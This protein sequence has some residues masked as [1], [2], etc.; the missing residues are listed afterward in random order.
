MNSGSWLSSPRKM[1]LTGMNFG[2]ICISMALVGFPFFNCVFDTLSGAT[3]N[4]ATESSADLAYTPQEK[5]FTTVQPAAVFPAQIP[6]SARFRK[7][8]QIQPNS[9]STPKARSGIKCQDRC[10]CDQLQRRRSVRVVIRFGIFK[11]A[12][13]ADDHLL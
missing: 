8:D 9:S 1:A 11:K 2:I 3:A 6:R 10:E 4:N 12:R 13:G 5:L 7:N